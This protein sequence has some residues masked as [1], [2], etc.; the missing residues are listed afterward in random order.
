M[1]DEAYYRETIDALNCEI[2]DLK[3][4]IN[5]NRLTMDDATALIA[6]QI[7]AL[8]EYQSLLKVFAYEHIICTM[9][10]ELP[11]EVIADLEHLRDQLEDDLLTRDNVVDEMKR[12][13]SQFSG[14]K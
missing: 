9:S 1:K 13:L 10:E 4:T 14:T 6:K 5:S 3:Q 7:A 12:I 8:A 11:D 2:D